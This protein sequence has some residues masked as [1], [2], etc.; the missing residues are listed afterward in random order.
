[1]FLNILQNPEIS[2]KY[3]MNNP[4]ILSFLEYDCKTNKKLLRDYSLFYYEINGIRQRYDW[5]MMNRRW[6]VG[7]W[8]TFKIFICLQDCLL[9]I[10]WLRDDC[11][12]TQNYCKM[13]V[14]WLENVLQMNVRWLRDDCEMTVRRLVKIKDRSIGCNIAN[15]DKLSDFLEYRA[16]FRA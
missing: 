12:M 1:M 10:L 11:E 4:L 3:N 7:D 9:S 6:L 15:C 5:V 16:T 8:L 13:I 14:T 2:L